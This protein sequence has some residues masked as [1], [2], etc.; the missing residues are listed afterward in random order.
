M[1]N[2]SN[3]ENN[4]VRLYKYFIMPIRAIILVVSIY[5]IIYF[6][7]GMYDNNNGFFIISTIALIFA[8]IISNLVRMSRIL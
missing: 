8:S 5:W 1:R 3:A 6:T 7:I 4:S 2:K